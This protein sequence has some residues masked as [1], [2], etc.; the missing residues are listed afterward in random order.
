MKTWSRNF[1]KA[2]PVWHLFSCTATSI[3]SVTN[4]NLHPL[5]LHHQMSSERMQT[6]RMQIQ[7]RMFSW[8]E[9]QA[10]AQLRQTHYV[11]KKKCFTG[12][13]PC[14]SLSHGDMKMQF[15]YKNKYTG[16]NNFLHWAHGHLISLL[17]KSHCT[18]T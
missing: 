14:Y 1:T 9:K 16:V 8:R 17:S 3:W 7:L 12:F 4:Y 11:H 5:Q 6:S 18:K 13:V 2:M 10:S 15:H